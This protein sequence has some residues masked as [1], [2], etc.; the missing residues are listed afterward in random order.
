VGKLRPIG[1]AGE[2]GTRTGPTG[3]A[4]GST[5]ERGEETR[6][7][8]RD[9][10]ARHDGKTASQRDSTRQGGAA[11]G[12]GTTSQ[13][14]T[15]T[16]R[17]HGKATPLNA[18]RRHGTTA[19]RTARHGGNA[20]PWQARRRRDSTSARQG[21]GP[22]VRRRRRSG[23]AAESTVQPQHRGAG[24][25][26][27]RRASALATASDATRDRWVN[28]D[29]GSTAA[30]GHRG[31]VASGGP[32]GVGH[33]RRLAHRRTTSRST[34]AVGPPTSSVVGATD[35]QPELSTGGGLRP[36]EFSLAARTDRTRASIHRATS[37]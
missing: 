34:A 32:R 25:A 16:T 4:G 12:N 1:L 20:G 22:R 37:G 6:P 35:N 27:G 24:F 15:A 18:T 33:P 30:P 3:A 8:P 5:A 36:P 13:R 31:D 21:G 7:T 11:R 28:R 29:T 17:N 9:K 19:P 2:T 14:D 26:K 23:E 10:P